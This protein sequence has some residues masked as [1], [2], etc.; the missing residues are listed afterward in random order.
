MTFVNA[1]LP[2]TIPRIGEIG[3]DGRVLGFTSALTVTAGLLFGTLPAV[4]AS[5]TA[6]TEALKAGS[7][8]L[9]GGFG[10]R[11]LRA[12]LV[13]SQVA[14]TVVLLTGAGL[15]IK[16]FVRLQQTPLGFRPE[17]LADGAHHTAGLRVFDATAATELRRPAARRGAQAAWDARGGADLFSA[18]CH[19]QPELWRS[20]EWPGKGGPGMPTALT[21]VR[22]AR[23]IF[24]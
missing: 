17:R 1:L 2:S 12:S 7:R 6:L 23:T 10:S 16:S 11:R 8:T 13:V 4:R 14:L 15:L 20:H 9:G 19:G 5:K 3:V 18:V 24:G 21:S 22:S